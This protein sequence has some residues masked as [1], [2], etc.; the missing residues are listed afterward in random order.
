MVADSHGTETRF[1]GDTSLFVAIGNPENR[2]YKSLQRSA[3]A[4]DISIQIPPQ[5]A[6]EFESGYSIRVKPAIGKGWVEI[7]DLEYEMGF[8]S[9]VMDAVREREAEKAE[10]PVHLI[11]KTDGA[12]AGLAA[13]LL[14]IGTAEKVSVLTA[15]DLLGQSAVE[16]IEGRGYAGQ[17]EFVPVFNYLDSIPEILDA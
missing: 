2:K 14:E 13:Q 10:E 17:I 9:S 4:R 5:V 7:S 8:V 12:V 3:L 11:K 15:D 1:V 16:I 6:D